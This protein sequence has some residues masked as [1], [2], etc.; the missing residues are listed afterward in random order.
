MVSFEPKY[1]MIMSDPQERLRFKP[2]TAMIGTAVAVI[3]LAVSSEYGFGRAVLVASTFSSHCRDQ[4][5]AQNVAGSEFHGCTSFPSRCVRHP[6]L[7]LLVSIKMGMVSRHATNFKTTTSQA[8]NAA[9]IQAHP[10]RN[11]FPTKMT[12]R[13]FDRS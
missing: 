13:P 5:H 6:A 10:D 2:R 11:W 1:Q 3:C 9:I 7:M 8:W 12:C 4:W